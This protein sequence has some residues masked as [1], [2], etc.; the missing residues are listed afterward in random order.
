MIRPHL[1]YVDF[2][3]ESGSKGL[4][5]KN[6]RL[7]E[8]ALCRIEFSYSAENKK[9]YDELQSLYGISVY[10]NL[11]ETSDRMSDAFQLCVGHFHFVLHFLLLNI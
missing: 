3:I 8:R 7:Q 11:F 6:D 10:E 9:S 1:E 5:T 4:V 2:I